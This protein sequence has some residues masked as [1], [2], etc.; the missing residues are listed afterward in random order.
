M[1]IRRRRN[2]VILQDIKENILLVNELITKI[3]SASEEQ[4]HGLKEI[5]GAMTQLND[6]TSYNS[7][8]ASVTSKEAQRLDQQAKEQTVLI[9]D[10]TKLIKPA[11]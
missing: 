4:A 1:V 2:A 3:A 5:S 10:L 6:S 11:A 7:N 8:I 9:E